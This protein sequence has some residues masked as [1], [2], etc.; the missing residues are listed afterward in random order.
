MA[1]LGIVYGGKKLMVLIMTNIIICLSCHIY[2]ILTITVCKSL[3]D[4]LDKNLT[5]FVIKD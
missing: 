4:S 5:V 2:G 1:V 3:H